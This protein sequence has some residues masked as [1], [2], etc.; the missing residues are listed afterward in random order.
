MRSTFSMH[1]VRLFGMQKVLGYFMGFEKFQKTIDH[2]LLQIKE[3]KIFNR[4]W[5]HDHTVWNDDS[6]EIGNRLGWL[7]SPEVMVGAIDQITAFV[8]E[9]R[10]AGYTRALLL[11]MGGSCLAAEVFRK[12]FDVKDGYLDLEVLDS[13]DPGAILEKA[14]GL[15]PS[16]TLFL[17]STKSGGTI[18]TISLMK[19]FY[20]KTLKAVGEE[21]MG[22]HFAAITD[23]GSSLETMATQLQFRKIFLN[24][25]N[26]GGRFSALSY[27]GLVPAALIGMDLNSILRRAS[28]MAETCDYPVHGDN[29]AAHLGA[30]MGVLAMVGRNK[31]TIIISPPLSHF[32]AWV[33]Q[34]IAES[35][36]KDG[37]GILPVVD[38]AVLPP[39]K[40][41]NDRLFVYLRLKN[42]RT[43]D[44]KVQALKD[45]G[46]PIIQLDLRD[47]Y[48]LCGEFFRWEMA[49]AIAGMLIGINP[50]DQPNVESAK[51]L[52]SEM[53]TTYQTKGMLPELMPTF[54]SEGIA[55]Y[56]DQVSGS[57]GEA[58]KKFIS[59]AEP[60][61]KRASSRSY[62]AL[63]A[64]VNPT[65]ENNA[66]LQG[67]RNKIQQ[68]YR[69][70]VT[71]GYGPRFLHSTGQLHKGDAGHGL[72]IQFTSEIDKDLPIPDRPG[73]NTSLITFGVLKSAQALGDRQA[74][75]DAG[76]RVIRF[77][78]GTD[79][80]SDLKKLT[81]ALV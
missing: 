70:A 71:V 2:A 32:G 3:K 58:L 51:I 24:D 23:P 38:E 72:F 35:T 80:S 74:L 77:H 81:D 25:P 9:I 45:D 27:F 44:E 68:T 10:T 39:D 41:E 63:Q 52:A 28:K 16:K 5:A 14:E 49:V 48:D 42:D 30:A 17:I 67:L 15:D 8:D 65:P 11:G 36:G 19:Y 20:N 78:L 31:V 21:T 73:E 60:G 29:T 66:A 53:V 64:Y 47:T 13:T 40:Y 1:A 18:E 22:D 57:V 12:T 50:F 46:K 4:I 7:H 56:T 37:K 54:V 43:F 26:I 59:R 33:E 34:L 75:L 6:S 76:R 62:V 61:K 79:I 55:V 69:L